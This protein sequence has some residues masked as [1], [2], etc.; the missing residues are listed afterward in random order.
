MNKSISRVADSGKTVEPGETRYFELYQTAQRQI[1]ELLLLDRLRSAIARQL[2]VT[3]IAQIVTESTVVLFGYPL[4]S[5][6]LLENDTL[7]IQNQVGYSNIRA[8]IPETDGSEWAAVKEKKSV[9]QRKVKNHDSELD[10]T[11]TVCSKICVPLFD[12]HTVT[13]LLIVETTADRTLSAT[14]LILLEAIGE[15]TSNAIWRARI[16]NEILETR[17]ALD[18]ERRLLR[19]VIDNIPDQIF[20]RDRECR[21]TL[22]NLKDAEMMG[23]S[24]TTELLGKCDLDFFPYELAMRYIDDDKKVLESGKPLINIVEPMIGADGEDRWIMTTKVPLRD[25]QD[26]VIGLVGIARDIT[27]QKKDAQALEEAKLQAE[28][29]NKAKST[30]LANMSHEI[31][32]PLNAILGFSQLLMREPNFTDQQ[33]HQLT[34]IHNSGEHLLQLINDILEISKIEAGRA[35][36]NQSTFDLHGMLHDLK[37]MFQVRMDEKGLIFDLIIE[38]RVPQTIVSDESKIRQILINLIGNAVKFTKQGRIRCI[39]DAKHCE[40]DDWQLTFQVEDSGIGITAEDI[41]TLFQVF[42]QAPGGIKEGGS[43]LGLA[44]SQRFARMLGGQINA[45]SEPGVGSCF[46]LEIMVREDKSAQPGR[47]TP[48]HKI[49]GIKDPVGT[50][51]ILVVDDVQESRELI[52]SLLTPVGFEIIEASDGREAFDIWNKVHPHLIIM[53]IR[54]PVMNGLEATVK[55]RET[56]NGNQVPI[57]AATASAFEEERQTILNAGMNGYLRKPI[58]EQDL[59]DLVAQCLG[60]EYTYHSSETLRDE[61]ALGMTSPEFPANEFNTIPEDVRGQMISACISADLDSLLDG[62]EQI[63]PKHSHAAARLQELADKL[64]YDDILS[65]LHG[66][67]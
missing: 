57:I 21:F 37:S 7:V 48:R 26:Q 55:I 42:Q 4:V 1:N 66:R 47:K 10:P 16:Y 2:N 41:Q 58:Q 12:Q 30:F 23:V 50:F 27:Q 8:R 18:K 25:N 65:L 36:I 56:D 28:E 32:T 35:T 44:I 53:D 64:Q 54:M 59:F 39:V 38:D 11:I 29:A 22:S 61:F 19:T 34:T 5:L 14:D 15:N 51:R 6:Y 43:G 31:R 17:E 46:S 45:A 20:A 62:V 67:S 52:T 3:S 60:I 13:G 24:N 63:I 49:S 33:R 9:L 40:Y